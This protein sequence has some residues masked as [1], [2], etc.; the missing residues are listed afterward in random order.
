V[1]RREQL[2]LIEQIAIAQAEVRRRHRGGR[3]VIA[4]TVDRDTPGANRTESSPMARR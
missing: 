2:P 4:A 1:I 3:T